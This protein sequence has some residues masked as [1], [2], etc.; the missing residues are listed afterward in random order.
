MNAEVPGIGAA[1]R[2][3]GKRV[4]RKEDPRLLTGRGQF[5]DD[6]SLPG[7]LHCAFAR[8]PIAR[9]RI[10][11]IDSTAARDV[12]GVHAVY[13][14]EDLAK[15]SF[16]MHTFFMVPTSVKTPTLAEDHVAYVFDDPPAVFCGDTLFA[17]GCGRL[18]EGSAETM[19]KSLGRLMALP[20]RTRVYCGHEYTQSNARFALHVDH[21]NAALV[22]RVAKI[23]ELRQA[24]E[25]TIP[26]TIGLERATNPFVRAGDAAEFGRL[27]AL[28]DQS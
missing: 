2:Y 3:I 15:V 22:A 11:S 21:E 4:L 25:P 17:A 16:T 27:R 1:A 24:G 10:V 7:M 9:G 26:S 23:D 19:W 13:T 20:D 6:I 8:S 5:V 14:A 12:P 18:F 28:K